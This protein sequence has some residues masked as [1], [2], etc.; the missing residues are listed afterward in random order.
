M[1]KIVI[2]DAILPIVR[3][4]EVFASSSDSADIDLYFVFPSLSLYSTEYVGMFSSLPKPT[5]VIT[6]RQNSAE[7][8]KFQVVCHKEGRY[9]SFLCE[10]DGRFIVIPSMTDK[11]SLLSSTYDTV[12]ETAAMMRIVEAFTP[13]M[14]RRLETIW[15]DSKACAVYSVTVRDGLWVPDLQWAIADAG[16]K[17][18]GHNGVYFDGDAPA[19]VDL[20]PDWPMD[21]ETWGIS[22][23]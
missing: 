16:R 9:Y 5:S 7:K 4:K 23:R 22:S 12:A 20:D 3:Q 8:R 11:G 1:D 13:V 10:K 18:G 2:A 15:C 21:D 19:G 14:K 17:V 6:L